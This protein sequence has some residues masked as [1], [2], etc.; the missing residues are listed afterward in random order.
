MISAYRTAVNTSAQLCAVLH[1]AAV[2]G[3]CL[4]NKL[5]K[6]VHEDVRSRPVIIGGALQVGAQQQCR[7]PHCCAL[8]ARTFASSAVTLLCSMVC[9]ASPIHSQL[10]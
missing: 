8:T 9:I 6:A 10:L 2:G 7:L 4:Q 5:D 3:Q 1:A